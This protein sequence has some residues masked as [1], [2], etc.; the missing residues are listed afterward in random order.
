MTI[1]VLTKRIGINSQPFIIAE[2]SANHNRSLSQALKIIKGAADAGFTA[3]K[4]QTYTADTMTIKYKN[5]Q[6]FIKD[7]NSPWNGR[8]LYKLY[9]KGSTPWIWHKKLFSYARKLGLIAFSTPFDSTSVDFLEKLKVPMYKI[10]SFEITDIP[11]ITKVASTKKPV[12]LSTG[13]ANIL[14][15]R[16][17]IKTLRKNGSKDIILLKCTSSYPTNLNDV[18]LSTIPILKKKFKCQIGLSDHT[19]G[20]IS[21]ITSI[22]FGATVIEK[23][24][25]INKKNS[26]DGLFSL[27]LSE[28]KKFVRDIRLAKKCIGKIKFG[29]T[30]TEIKNLKYRRSIVATKDIKKKEKFSKDNIKCLR[31]VNGLEP[32]FYFRILNKK[33]K[34]NIKYGE[35]IKLSYFN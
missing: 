20:G 29:P 31:G 32:K 9:E 26:I 1:K 22:G 13:M 4:L 30:K 11:L 2:V 19:I 8:D 16:E 12:I 14:E 33:S 25:T 10:S 23:H 3:V 34:K 7:K 28:L 21:A 27:D 24:I 17:A 18:N 6:S 35:A 5:K 15:I